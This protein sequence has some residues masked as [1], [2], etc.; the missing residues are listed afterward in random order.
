MLGYLNIYIIKR[1]DHFDLHL[2]KK[3]NIIDYLN[4]SILESKMLRYKNKNKQ[5]E[6]T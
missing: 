6:N 4:I 2:I 1:I 3:N 5:N